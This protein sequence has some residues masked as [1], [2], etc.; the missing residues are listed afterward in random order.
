MKS[1]ISRP[2]L[3]EMIERSYALEDKW[4]DL[5]AD[6]RCENGSAAFRM[7][8]E[9]LDA[10]MQELKSYFKD[11]AGRLFEA[12]VFPSREVAQ[13]IINASPD[14]RRDYIGPDGVVPDDGTLNPDEEADGILALI[15]D[16]NFYFRAPIAQGIGGKRLNL[17]VETKSLKAR[18]TSAH[19]SL[20]HPEKNARR[21]Y[22]VDDQT[23]RSLSEKGYVWVEGEITAKTYRHARL[24][25]EEFK[26]EVQGLLLTLGFCKFR[27]C[28]FIN[29]PEMVIGRGS[30]FN[31]GLYVDSIAARMAPQLLPS[32]DQVRGLS[33][34]YEDNMKIAARYLNAGVSDTGE[35]RQAL[36]MFLRSFDAWSPGEAAML[37]STTLEGL[38]LDKRN[39][40]DLSARLQD[41][42]SFY[43]GESRAK[44]AEIRN[45]VR[46]L[47]KAR[48]S[49]VHNGETETGS[50]R[51]DEVMV[52]VQNVLRKELMAGA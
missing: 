20:K 16:K 48:S 19:D 52:L 17:S 32:F 44:R 29:P 34:S 25:I 6:D 4:C 43:V 41:A 2:K 49:F 5:Q 38:L 13:S 40:D 7:R 46:D 12:G 14:D 22:Y 42:V 8:K 11:L 27:R 36:K 18:I 45:I 33:E 30:S 26:L 39:K 47:Y 10:E 24:V 51:I 9:A 35:L 28:A 21:T 50:L 1:D 23:K 37:L 3:I 31:R 15:G